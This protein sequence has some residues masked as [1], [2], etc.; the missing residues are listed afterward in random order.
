MREIP[1]SPPH[2]GEEEVSAVSEALRS[3][4][5]SM[6]PKTAEFEKE[7]AK[8]VGAKEAVAVNSCTSGLFLSLIANGVQP[9]DEVITTPYTFASTAN[10]IEHLGAQTVF[11][12]VEPGTLNID[13]SEIGKKITEKTKGIVVV[14]YAGQPADMDEINKIA[15][16]HGLFVNEDAAH[17]VGA[18]YN[19]RKIGSGKN[20]VSFSFYATKNLTT[21][22][23]GMVTLEDPEKAGLLRKMRL[24]GMS[25]DAWKRYSGEGRWHYQ[26]EHPGYKM[27]TTDINSALG[28]TQLRQ[29]DEFNRKRA[30]IAK[31][32]RDGLQGIEGMSF[33][34]L[35]KGRKTCDHLFPVFVPLEKRDS[36]IASL[37]KAGIGTSVHFIPLHIM[38]YYK[39]KY[40]CAEGDYPNAFNAYK[41]EVSLPIYPDLSD[42]D[43]AYVAE[44]VKKA[45]A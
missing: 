38:P 28:L 44:N 15:E 41:K 11:A 31:S 5:L 12:D 21:G 18:E 23:G 39:D 24:H 30:E 43:V 37:A 9:G 26:I 13:P 2:V 22:E 10:T 7:F 20:L 14:H 8:Y 40:G 29:V 17:A 33:L 1:F 35:K 32:Y 27:N 16:E 34:E 42:N 45:L 36:L 6:G 25:K 19:G 3:G 4:W